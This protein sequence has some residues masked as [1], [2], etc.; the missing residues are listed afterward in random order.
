MGRYYEI[1]SPLLRGAILSTVYHIIYENGQSHWVPLGVILVH[2]L[3]GIDLYTVCNEWNWF[4][5][6]KAHEYN[7]ITILS[8]TYVVD[9]YLLQGQIP[10]WPPVNIHISEDDDKMN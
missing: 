7:G 4:L 9:R 3:S 6:Y 1:H 10:N 5:L 2:I 8:M